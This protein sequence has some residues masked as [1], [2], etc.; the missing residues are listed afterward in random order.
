MCVTPPPRSDGGRLRSFSLSL[1]L[2]SSIFVQVVVAPLSLCLPDPPSHDGRLRCSSRSLDSSLFPR[3]VVALSLP[4]MDVAMVVS[5]VRACGWVCDC[6]THTHTPSHDFRLWSFSL[7]LFTVVLFSGWW[8]PLSLFSLSPGRWF[9]WWCRPRARAGECVF[10][11]VG[12]T[13]TTTFGWSSPPPRVGCFP[14][15]RGMVASSLCLSLLQEYNS[16]MTT[17]LQ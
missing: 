8:S 6:V 5:S 10:V 16:S 2:R 7:S 14:L 17:V 11:C 15:L 12:R 1:C 13:T 4:D 9:R 3:V